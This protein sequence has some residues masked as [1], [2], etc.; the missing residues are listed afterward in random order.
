[1]QKSLQHFLLISSELRR[2]L[3]QKVWLNEIIKFLPLIPNVGPCDGCLTHANTFFLKADPKAWAKPI[4]VVL[5]PSPRGVGVILKINHKNFNIIIFNNEYN[6]FHWFFEGYT[7]RNVSY[8]ST[9]QSF[10]TQWILT[11]C[12]MS[13]LFIAQ[14]AKKFAPKFLLN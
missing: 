5:F 6:Y 7:M 4:V 9:V 10:I 2:K 11:H 1:M 3:I 13:G 14:S 12:F 8:L